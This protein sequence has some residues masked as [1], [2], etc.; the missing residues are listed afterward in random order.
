MLSLSKEEQKKNH[1]WTI[2]NKFIYMT[3]NYYKEND[4]DLYL[5][6]W[7]VFTVE[8]IHFKHTKVHT[9]YENTLS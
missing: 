3:I 5:W 2:I 4:F 9:T 8:K 1:E 7:K 6:F